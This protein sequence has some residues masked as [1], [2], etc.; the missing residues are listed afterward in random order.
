MLGG[1]EQSVRLEV[2]DEFLGQAGWPTPVSCEELEPKLS[3]AYGP[4]QDWAL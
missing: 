3:T 2:A 1:L 4:G